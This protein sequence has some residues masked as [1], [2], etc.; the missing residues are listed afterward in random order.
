MRNT[1]PDLSLESEIL[2]KSTC[3]T[4]KYFRPLRVSSIK[5]RT[6]IHPS[7][8]WGKDSWQE[9]YPQGSLVE[10]A[11]SVIKAHFGSNARAKLVC[12][13]IAFESHVPATV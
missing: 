1:N 12:Q 5:T 4:K 11:F 8:R 13:S 3:K 9:V 6:F 10:T 7:D 2:E